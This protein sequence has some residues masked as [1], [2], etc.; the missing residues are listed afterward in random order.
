M[1]YIL[2]LAFV[3]FFCAVTM[4]RDKQDNKNEFNK[5]ILGYLGF[6]GF[7]A[8]LYHSVSFALCIAL[9]I[10]FDVSD[11]FVDCVSASI[12]A[13]TILYILCYTFINAP[14]SK[15]TK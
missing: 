6:F 9:M 14:N 11:I 2:L 3:S 10:L 13:F 5:K 8:I 4:S 7:I 15:D 12:G 1:A